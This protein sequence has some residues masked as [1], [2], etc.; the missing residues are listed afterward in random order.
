MNRRAIAMMAL[1]MVLGIG[2]V[3]G[4][5]RVMS[6]RAATAS[7]RIVVAAKDLPPG[8]RLSA[9]HLTLTS[10]P[11]GTPLAGAYKDSKLL[12]SRVVNTSVPRGTPIVE[13]KLAPP[14]AR[15]GLS[16]VI[17][18]GKRAMTVKVNEVVGVAGFALPG[19]LV[20]VVLN[21]KGADAAPVSK[22]V[23]EQI[24]VL[25]IAQ[26]ASRD[27]AKPKV[28]SAV[29]LEVTPQ[30][31]EK[32]DLG[33]SIGTLSLVLRNQGDHLDVVTPGMR[34]TELLGE[35]ARGDLAGAARLRSTVK[36][37]GAADGASAPKSSGKA[38]APGARRTVE[39]IRGSTRSNMEVTVF[40]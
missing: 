24:M 21:T 2:A 1:S 4:A 36:K 5:A 19:N 23:L 22:I 14:G 34:R 31:A 33:R 17:A 37:H 29:T 13:A 6:A 8:T 38:E 27:D 9:E 10:W 7:A 12:D 15:G 40:E 35:V 26:E 32:L 11:V 18:E 20:D 30:Q 39:V 3:M 25:A 28:V 16:A